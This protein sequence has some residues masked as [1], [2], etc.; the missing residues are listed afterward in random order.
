[1]PFFTDSVQ[2]L[3]DVLIKEALEGLVDSKIIGQVIRTVK[4]ADLFVLLAKQE[5]VL[6][7]AIER[8][9]EI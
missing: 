3:I 2:L 5:A 1:M 6:E 9:I 8:L 7:G 4:C